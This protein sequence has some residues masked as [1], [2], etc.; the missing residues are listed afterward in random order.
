MND[1][2]PGRFLERERRV[3]LFVRV[4]TVPAIRDCWAV[5]VSATGIGLSIG[6]RGPLEAP[7]EGEVIEI[8]LPLPGTGIMLRPK[9]RVRW[10][11]DRSGGAHEVSTIALGV[12]FEELR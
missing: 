1:K 8:E 4:V 7:A 6:G 3:P 2:A 11:Y 10:R 9:G 5:D 12:S